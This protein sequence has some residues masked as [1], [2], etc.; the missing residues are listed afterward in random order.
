LDIAVHLLILTWW[1]TQQNMTRNIT[2]NAKLDLANDTF[3]D[4][5]EGCAE[6]MEGKSP[7]LLKE[8]LEANQYLK[9]E[10]EKAEQRWKQ[11]K[12]I[13]SYSK[14]F[15]D[16]HGT[17]IVAYTGD[18][19]TKFNRAVREFCQNPDNFQFKAFLY[20]LTRAPQLLNPGKCYT[21][22]R[23]C[24]SKFNYSGKGNVCFG[25]FA[26]SSLFKNTAASPSFSGETL[27]AIRTCLGVYIKAFSYYPNEE[28]VL[29]P[30][31]EVYQATTREN[32]N[33]IYNIILLGSPQKS[34]SNFNCFYHKS[35]KNLFN[36]NSS[37]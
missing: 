17:A 22:Y 24:K 11:I 19:A 4:Q 37:G 1:L 26:S 28:E 33:K 6:E 15:N 13:V 3:D 30:G 27:F 20:Y 10:W 31:Y 21:V 9:T 25:Q 36:F 18:I 35:I 2:C 8:E 23:G 32:T 7:Q 34:K 5:Y 16:F 14:Q 12:N 29:I